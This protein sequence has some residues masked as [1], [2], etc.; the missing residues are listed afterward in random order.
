[1]GFLA[2]CERAQFEQGSLREMKKENK[3]YFFILKK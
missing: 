2:A 1:V 3:S